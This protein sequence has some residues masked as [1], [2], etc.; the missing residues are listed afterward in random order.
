MAT[1]YTY[2]VTDNASR[3]SALHWMFDRV[4]NQT[5]YPA[6]NTQIQYVGHIKRLRENVDIRL[7][8]DSFTTDK[9]RITAITCNI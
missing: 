2:S 4:E 7:K 1:I 9:R 3:R 8:L 5:Y 6:S